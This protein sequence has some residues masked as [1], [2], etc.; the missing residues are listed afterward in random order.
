MGD[1]KY[2]FPLNSFFFAK[3]AGFDVTV[4]ST[5]VPLIGNSPK[6][7]VKQNTNTLIRV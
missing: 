2:N 7:L 1:N 6:I 4:D 5:A 3:E